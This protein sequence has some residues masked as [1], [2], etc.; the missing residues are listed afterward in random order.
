MNQRGIT[1]VEVVIAAAIFVILLGAAA[2]AV[3]RDQETYRALTTQVGREIPARH[4]LERIATELR[5][6]GEWAEDKDHDGELDEGE[7][8]N[9]N[10]VLDAAWDL[11]DGASNQAHIHFNRRVDLRDET[12]ALVASGIYTRA[13]GYRLEG[14]DLVR[15]WEH[16][17]EDGSITLRRTVIARGIGGLR[18]SRTGVLVT[19]ELDLIVPERAYAP[20]SRTLA[21]RVWLRN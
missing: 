1:L 4:A 6:A 10:G 9:D 13:V 17:E 21:L 8:S 12:G 14:T 2:V 5:M 20:G 11:P 16:G 3:A 19:A 7:D 15:E 18:F